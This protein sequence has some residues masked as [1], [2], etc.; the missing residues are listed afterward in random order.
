MICRGMPAVLMMPKVPHHGRVWKHFSTS[1][2]TGQ[3]SA[4][5]RCCTP[6]R[7]VHRE[8]KHLFTAMVIHAQ[9]GK[10]P[11][12]QLPAGLHCYHQAHQKR[13]ATYIHSNGMS[14]LAVT[15]GDICNKM[16][17]KSIGGGV[18]THNGSIGCLSLVKMLGKEAVHAST[19]TESGEM[20]GSEKQ[21]SSL[22]QKSANPL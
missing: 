18:C 13:F 6:T 10:G 22:R 2:D 7:L 1:K 21:Q 14:P 16:P 9:S 19:H 4:F 11:A 12:R 8:L 20:K 5:R 3:S 15:T 17:E